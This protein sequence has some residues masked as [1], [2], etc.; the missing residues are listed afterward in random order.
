M[1]L[2]AEPSKDEERNI[3]EL[4][5]AT[6]QAMFA[7][8]MTTSS[9]SGDTGSVSRSSSLSP[10]PM[11]SPSTSGS[12]SGGL[13]A[14]V[15]SPSPHSLIPFLNAAS[16]I[17]QYL[18]PLAIAVMVQQHPIHITANTTTATASTLP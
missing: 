4:D 7:G 17:H 14:T 13:Q 6:I 1:K 12:D 5:I 10:G 3:A 16:A 11:S 18:F 9:Q 2:L 8:M 15:E